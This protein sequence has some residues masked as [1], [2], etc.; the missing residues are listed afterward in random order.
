MTDSRASRTTQQKLAIFRAC[1]SGLTHV[2]GTYD[3]R[4]GKARQVKEPVTDHVILSH[5][6]GQALQ[7]SD[8][9]GARGSPD[10]ARDAGG[11]P[12]GPSP[13][14]ASRGLSANGLPAHPARQHRWMKRADPYSDSN[15]LVI[16]IDGDWKCVTHRMIECDF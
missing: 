12:S 15:K 6:K 9:G 14:A 8:T 4:T 11:T 2:Y 5:L 13:V 1:F 3:P 10:A 7:G 16:V